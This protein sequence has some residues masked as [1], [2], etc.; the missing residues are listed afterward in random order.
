MTESPPAAQ[1]ATNGSGEDSL[2]H[3]RNLSV[4]FRMRIHPFRTDLLTAVDGVNL[5]ISRGRTFGL[6]GESG[7][8]KTSLARAILRLI[9]IT[10]GQVVFD[11]IDIT[12][13]DGKKLRSLRRR[14]QVVF[15]DQYGCLPSGM[16]V[17]RIV[18]EPLAV[19]SSE[20]RQ[21]R[22]QIVADILDKVG[23]G[24]RYA[25]RRPE[26][27]SGGERQRVNIARAIV[28]SP[29]LVICDEPVSAQDALLQ[30]QIVELLLRLQEELTLTYL[31]IAHDL[32]LI[33]HVAQRVAVMY[34]GRIVE[35]GDRDQIFGNPRHPYTQELLA[36]T[37]RL[38]RGIRAANEDS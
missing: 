28:L 18:G 12:S 27:L 15:Q 23:L 38:G 4:H 34:Q 20:P 7:C 21:R 2:L 26:E 31:F 16:T 1:A 24:Q 10:S 17:A 30:A 22:R 13:I 25:N 35:I 29:E 32:A 11:G 19:H 3:V 8:G 5:D 37:P 36:A 9:P 6:V 14:M 33:R